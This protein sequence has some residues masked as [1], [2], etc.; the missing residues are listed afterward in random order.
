VALQFAAAHN[1][2]GDNYAKNLA[3]G[4][5]AA[6]TELIDSRAFAQATVQNLYERFVKQEFS[7]RAERDRLVEV[8]VSSSY[9]FPELVKAIVKLPAYRRP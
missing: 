1:K 9:N 2:A 3:D 7:D 6:A 8:F 4:P 5:R